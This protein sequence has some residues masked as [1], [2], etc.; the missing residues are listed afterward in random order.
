MRA[1]VDQAELVAYSTK[2]EDK[3]RNGRD[4]AQGAER[5]GGSRRR[6]R[7]ISHVDEWTGD[8]SGER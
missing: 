4:K 6:E 1:C 7:V 2:V 3:P 5:S 8:M